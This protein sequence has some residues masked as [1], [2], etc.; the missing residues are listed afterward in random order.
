M[1]EDKIRKGEEKVKK[2]E[3]EKRAMGNKE[4]EIEITVSEIEPK[5]FLSRNKGKIILGVVT[6]VG[7]AAYFGVKKYLAEK[8]DIIEL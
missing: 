5:G 8:V 2:L 6:V 4:E 1:I 3:D 7:V